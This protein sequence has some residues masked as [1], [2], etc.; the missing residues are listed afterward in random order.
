MYSLQAA[1]VQEIKNCSIKDGAA[2]AGT[3]I[4]LTRGI[5][6]PGERWSWQDITTCA[7]LQESTDNR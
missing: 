4:S 5:A 7:E 2:V 3:Y 1:P 6:I